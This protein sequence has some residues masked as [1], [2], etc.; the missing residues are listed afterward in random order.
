MTVDADLL[1]AHL[2]PV[3]K[4]GH[5]LLVAWDGL[6]WVDE[7]AWVTAMSGVESVGTNGA[8]NAAEV[9]V[10]L[11]NSDRRYSADNSASPIY[12]FLTHTGQKA[13]LRLGYDGHL[14]DV[15]TFWIADLDPRESDATA[16]MR[17]LDRSATLADAT[18]NYPPA[19]DVS[20]DEIMRTMLTAAGYVETTDFVLDVAEAHA[21]FAA[22][23]DAKLGPELQQI[24]EAEGGRVYVDPQGVIRFLNHSSHEAALGVPLA[25]FVRSEIAY[26]VSYARRR[27]GRITRLLLGYED[28]LAALAAE[29]IFDQKSPIAIP[30]C[31]TSPLWANSV[32]VDHPY[33]PG[34][35]ATTRTVTFDYQT[36]DPSSPMY[37]MVGCPQITLTA[38]YEEIVAAIPEVLAWSEWAPPVQTGT[39]HYPGHTGIE[40]KGMD[41]T[42]WERELPVEFTTLDTI[43]ANTKA[44]GTGTAVTCTEGYGGAEESGYGTDVLWQ[45][46]P[47][48]PTGQM[49]L[50]NTTAATVWVTALKLLGKPAR[51]VSPWSVIANDAEAQDF[52][53]IVE[54]K[55]SNAYLPTADLAMLRATEILFFRSGVRARLDIPAMDGAPYLHPRDA[56]AFVDDSVTPATTTY[57]Q[58]LSNTWRYA[59]DAGYTCALTTAPALP[60]TL[61]IVGTDAVPA[62]VS[63]ALA[64]ASDSGPWYWGADAD[65]LVWTYSDWG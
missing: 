60:P 65:P 47:N 35:P 63:G 33:V 23:T 1:A 17:L 20:L 57:L 16:S 44:D 55:V 54:E 40:V 46:T 10:D 5:Q 26:D 7:S 58:V 3:H 13:L 9:N 31:E 43:T 4:P 28:R 38:S 27:E 21:Q 19:G 64:T 53:G 56:F 39:G 48:G 59:P 42:R 18:V 41:L 50:W 2:A 30:P 22:A 51:T 25:T 6:N 11:D 15:G 32:Q 12:S 49:S 24:A 34:V 8:L 45:W 52:F 14:T 29:V 37:G 62:P 61:A 36:A